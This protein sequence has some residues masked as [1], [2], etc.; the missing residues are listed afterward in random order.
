MYTYRLPGNPE[1]FSLNF[2]SNVNDPRISKVVD[3]LE[4]IVVNRNKEKCVGAV[5]FA[6]YLDSV[7]DIISKL[8]SEGIAVNLTLNRH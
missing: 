5:I 1:T 6:E 3:E 4:S 8:K 7:V 2:E